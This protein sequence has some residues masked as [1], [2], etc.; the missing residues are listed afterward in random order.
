FYLI[1]CYF[2]VGPF[3]VCGFGIIFVMGVI[4]LHGGVGFVFFFFFFVGGGGGGWVGCCFFVVVLVVWG[5]FLGF[6]FCVVAFV[7]AP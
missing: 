3:V 2:F 5:F 6:V 4:M 7:L 1:G